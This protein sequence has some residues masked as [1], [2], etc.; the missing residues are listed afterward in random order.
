MS[1]RLQCCVPFCTRSRG[2][3]K[4]DPIA[5]YTEWICAAHYA[6]VDKSLKIRRQRL[7][8]RHRGSRRGHWLDQLVWKK[9]K[10]QA[11]ERAMGH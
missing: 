11:I 9:M 5:Q 7:R 8:R 10:R 4:G 2:D 3:R 6:L 1:K